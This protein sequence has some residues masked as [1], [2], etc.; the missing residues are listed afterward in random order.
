MA[1]MKPRNPEPE[2]EPQAIVA[3][4]DWRKPE[5]ARKRKSVRAEAWQARAW[6]FWDCCGELRYAAMWFANA[7]SRA[8]LFIGEPQPDGSVKRITSGPEVDAL[9]E[10]THEDSSKLL[11][12]IGQHYFIGGEWYLVG[13]RSQ[14][15]Q[16]QWN[17]HSPQEVKYDQ[18]KWWL[19]KGLGHP[20]QEL[21]NEAVL[22]GWNPHPRFHSEPDSPVRAVLDDLEEI[23]LLSL[24]IK[25]Q[26]NSRLAGAG[27]LVLPQELEFAAPPNQEGDTSVSSANASEF[28][29]TLA[30]AMGTA[31]S[32]P[33]S[34]SSLVPITVTAPGEFIEKI[35]HLTFWS[36]LDEKST[37]MR[38]DA[39]KRLALG[40]DLPPEVL[41]GT[42]EINHWGAW[43]IEESSIKAHIEPA[44]Q[45]VCRFLTDDY[46]HVLF[47]DSR[48]GVYSDTSKLRMRPNRSKEAMELY[49]MG[50][51]NEEA[52]MR[53]TGF[54][55]E[56]LPNDKDIQNFILLKIASGSATP[57]MVAAAAKQ[58]GVD[59]PAVGDNMNEARPDT[60]LLEHP[61]QGPPRERETQ[62]PQVGDEVAAACHVL[63]LR[64]LERAGN[65]MKTK[66]PEDS[67]KALSA[68]DVYRFVR[69]SSAIVD[70]L[71]TDAWSM[72]PDALAEFAGLDIEKVE[73]CLDSYARMVIRTQGTPSLSGL[74]DYL[75]Q[76][77]V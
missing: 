43:Q 8:E 26:I 40:L 47:P 52:L 38:D 19:E 22:H 72:T 10:L 39:V 34:P 9:N 29:V 11:K 61:Y 45:T 60:S 37:S 58:L 68:R 64:A 71:L 7:L 53:E 27:L 75:Q 63:V 28:M 13:V 2:P 18:G 20:R 17:V 70:D 54:S 33:S 25:A 23:T 77:G 31:I 24:H 15:H 69:P 36:D 74:R 65:R 62:P 49:L 44:L 12:Q 35:Q 46:L 14:H 30:R 57:D 48:R 4:I 16:D 76:H 55:S 3:A 56:D 59:I 32:D 67:L 42:A 6:E 5:N 51:L 1:R 50:K 73:A 66:M 41:T 21:E